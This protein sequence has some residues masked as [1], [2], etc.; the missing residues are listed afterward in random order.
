MKPFAFMAGV[1]F[2]NINVHRGIVRAWITVSILWISYA[3]YMSGVVPA[4][5]QN[6]KGNL[7]S[8][9]IASPTYASSH[10]GIATFPWQRNWSDTSKRSCAE[11]RKLSPDLGD[12]SECFDDPNGDRINTIELKATV[13]NFIW[14]GLIPPLAL[15]LLG[16]M[17]RWVIRGF[18]S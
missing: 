14:L 4:T 9:G 16:S 7:Y 6:I 5:L 8:F 10:G 12:P 13:Y 11:A 17:F 18:L 2:M 1:K 15:L 3:A